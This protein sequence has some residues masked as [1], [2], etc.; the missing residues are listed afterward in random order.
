M[1]ENVDQKFI[2]L[3]QHKLDTNLNLA[4]GSIGEFEFPQFIAIPESTFEKLGFD[5]QD[6][7]ELLFKYHLMEMIHEHKIL[8][9]PPRK[10][11]KDMDSFDIKVQY[12]SRLKPSEWENVYVLEIYP[13]HYQKLHNMIFSNDPLRAIIYNAV[14]GVGLLR[15]KKFKFKNH[16]PEFMLFKKLYEVLNRPIKRDEM[17]E[18]LKMKE[19]R[20]ATIAINDLVK[21]IRSR[22]GLTTEELVLNNGDVTLSI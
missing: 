18:I 8:S 4:D 16:Q 22:T 17:L 5:R 7:D 6:V 19:G 15:K 13:W 1:G 11:P 21:K 10:E 20:N 12:L 9:E 14:T 2:R 3:I